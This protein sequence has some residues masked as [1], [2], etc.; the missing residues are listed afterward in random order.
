MRG[1]VKY[2]AEICFVASIPRGTETDWSSSVAFCRQHT[3][4]FFINSYI[5]KIISLLLFYYYQQNWQVLMY[6]AL[7]DKIS[8]KMAQYTNFSKR[9][10]VSAVLQHLLH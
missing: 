10:L 8:N 1:R 9:S 5:N 2:Y 7:S 3:A 4:I 6:L